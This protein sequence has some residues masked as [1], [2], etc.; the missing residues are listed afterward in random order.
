MFERFAGDA[1]VA[2]VLA[3]EE[4]RMAGHDR[5]DVEHVLL[6]VLQSRDA[7]LAAL[8]AEAGLTVDEAR[9]VVRQPRR[10]DVLGVQ[11]AE[12]L[13][14][15]GIDLDAVKE[16]LASSFG[17]DALAGP[18]L[19]PR[20]RGRS[21]LARGHVP[22][23]RQAKKV[24]ELSL[25]EA[26]ARNDDHIDAAHLLLG[27]LRAPTDTVTAVIRP[28]MELGELRGRVVDLLDRAA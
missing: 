23:T 3:Q 26:L 13:R 1:R 7:G 21:L 20:R 17:P 12:A 22:I 9:S 15:I 25:R 11:D 19:R 16:S 18:N 5:I 10:D 28:H 8:L 4:A 14:S 6:G 27:V 24:I 2:L